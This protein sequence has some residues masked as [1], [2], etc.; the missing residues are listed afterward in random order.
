MMFREWQNSM[1]FR[2][3]AI[4]AR[5]QFFRQGDAKKIWTDKG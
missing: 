1:K 3:V 5:F 4:K 2:L